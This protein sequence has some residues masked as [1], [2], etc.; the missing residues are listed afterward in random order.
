[1][2]TVKEEASVMNDDDLKLT[3]MGYKPVSPRLLDETLIKGIGERIFNGI[4]NG[5]GI[6][7]YQ[8]SFLLKCIGN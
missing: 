3:E 6:Q 4:R 8:V 1:M 2:A 5:A 7:Y